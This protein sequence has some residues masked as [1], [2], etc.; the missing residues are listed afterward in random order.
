MKYNIGAL[1]SRRVF[2]ILV[3]TVLETAE[4]G[5]TG[6]VVS[7]PFDP[8]SDPSLAEA[9]PKG[10]RG[11]YASVEKVMEMEDGKVEWRFVISQQDHLWQ[12]TSPKNGYYQYT[13]RSDPR[14]PKWPCHSKDYRTGETALLRSA[15]AILTDI[16]L[17]MFHIFSSG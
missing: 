7:L 11:M 16:W 2:T 14:F 5:R 1:L 4:T 10:V 3:V 15:R 8:T 6:W 9:E 13:R 17:R 12:L